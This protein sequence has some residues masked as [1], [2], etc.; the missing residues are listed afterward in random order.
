MD[1]KDIDTLLKDIN[2]LSE[3]LKS[4]EPNNLITNLRIRKDT[5]R[6]AKAAHTVLL[7]TLQAAESGS[8]LPKYVRECIADLNAVSDILKVHT[9]ASAIWRREVEGLLTSL[10]PYAE[11]NNSAPIRYY[12]NT[13]KSQEELERIFHAL[14]EHKY[15]S[16]AAPDSMQ[17]FFNA[18]DSDA[19]KPQGEIKWIWIP[20]NKQVSPAQILDFVFIMAGAEY[21]KVV[22]TAVERIFGI[23]ISETVKSRNRN[24][25]TAI[26]QDLLSIVKME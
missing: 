4:A 11:G 26:Y 17:N 9:G 20:K 23:T 8:P 18:F 24:N 6:I 22:F 5:E 19:Q 12:L 15:I 10:A 7:D 21:D 1:Y 14:V 13:N 25:Q 2:G 16:G 3:L